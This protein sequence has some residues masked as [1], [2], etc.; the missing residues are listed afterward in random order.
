MTTLNCFEEYELA[1]LFLDILNGQTWSGLLDLVEKHAIAVRLARAYNKKYS[2][3]GYHGWEDW[4]LSS[5]LNSK[6]ILTY[7]Y[8]QMFKSRSSVIG[9]IQFSHLILTILSLGRVLSNDIGIIIMEP[10]RSKPD[11][12]FLNYIKKFV[13]KIK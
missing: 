12:K 13:L 4:Y 6:R 11:E 2:F 5:N 10:Y 3:C 8:C 1:E 7:S 9:K